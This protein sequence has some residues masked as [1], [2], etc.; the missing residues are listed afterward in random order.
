MNNSW[1]ELEDAIRQMQL[2]NYDKPSPITHGICPE[3]EKTLEAEM[4]SLG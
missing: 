4:E 2:F 3:C 1:E